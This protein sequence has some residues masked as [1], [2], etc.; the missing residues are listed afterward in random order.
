MARRGPRTQTESTQVIWARL[1]APSRWAYTGAVA[2][3]P[4]FVAYLLVAGL[5]RHRHDLSLSLTGPTVVIVGLAGWITLRAVVSFA[6]RPARHGQPSVRPGLRRPAAG[7]FAPP[8]RAEFGDLA[9]LAVPL[10]GG[11]YLL[12]ALGV[13]VRLRLA[14]LAGGPRYPLAGLTVSLAI[15][16]AGLIALTML[17]RS[18]PA[19]CVVRFT[20]DG[21]G[22]PG[23]VGV[24]IVVV[25]LAV[26]A[27]AALNRHSDAGVTLSTEQI[28]PS[29]LIPLLTLAT[30]VIVVAI[31]TQAPIDEDQNS[32]SA[33]L[34]LILVAVG[35]GLVLAIGPDRPSPSIAA[36][37]GLIWLVAARTKDR[38]APALGLA[39]TLATYVLVAALSHTWHRNP[40]TPTHAHVT[41]HAPD[42]AYAALALARASTFGRGPGQGLVESYAPNGTVP[43]RY[44]LNVIAEELGL[45]GLLLV[46]AITILVGALLVRLAAR[47]GH[48]LLGAWARGVTAATLITLALPVLALLWTIGALLGAAS[49][50][51]HTATP[52]QQHPAPP[53]PPRWTAC[54]NA[55]PAGPGNPRSRACV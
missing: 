4:A 36:T 30:F 34:V 20:G 28:R 11:V 7:R 18:Q 22:M 37:V 23:P 47:C 54:A 52:A 42:D 45:L 32:A 26:V 19:R 3:V 51:T 29:S 21:R 50:T 13:L 33:Y 1:G 8:D 39:A 53:P 24:A 43:D 9:R 49:R 40:Y 55:P 48:G 25:T 6:D 35:A 12:V 14:G 41:A 44:A 10:V 46:L 27:L 5:Q 15:G 17:V 2:F 38:W 16:S 31:W